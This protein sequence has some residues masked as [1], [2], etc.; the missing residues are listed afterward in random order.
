MSSTFL[1]KPPMGW[2][3]WDCYGASV[4]EDEVLAN[5]RFM[6][7]KLKR[8]GWEYITVDIQWSEPGSLGTD[9]R[10]LPKLCMDEY[11]RQ[12]PAENR[13]PSAKDGAGFK[14]LADAVHAMGL[15][16]GIHILR[17]I[18]RQ[19]V[20][21]DC[22][23]M[24]TEY[25]AR[26]IA[27]GDNLCPWNMDMYGVNPDHPGAQAYYDSIFKLYADWG[28]DLV[29][30][31]DMAHMPY[32]WTKGDYYSGE[33]HL[34][35]NAIDK[36]GRNMVFSS[37]PGMYSL[38]AAG[39]VAEC[40][41]MWRISNDFWDDWRALD[42]MYDLL[43]KWLPH[44][45]EG[46]YPDA[47]MIPIGHLSVRSNSD[48]NKPRMTNFTMNEQHFL[49]SLWSIARSPMILGCDMPGMDDFTLS[50]LTNEYIIGINQHSSG[51]RMVFKR[52]SIGAWAC[53]TDEGACIGLF[54]LD[55]STRA[56]AITLEE[57]GIEGEYDVTDAWTGK[58][59][60]YSDGMLLCKLGAHEGTLL[61]LKRKA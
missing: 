53:E 48:W 29:K 40:C 36:C 54:N 60:V 20:Y 50:L 11:G 44:M 6:A 21:A 26:D 49:M 61:R 30:V 46:H 57:A 55:N 2:N 25:T 1:K 41:N 4:R 14:P 31:D 34:I 13:F 35:R 10:N 32:F 38:D 8:Y 19:A 7:D 47:D 56:A 51:S 45:S 42:E 15:K 24:G 37:S 12:I 52:D 28:V 39:T 33:A 9:Y 16:F 58:P 27:K 3:S 18:P 43:T 17:G 23:V 5:A 59:V 22:P